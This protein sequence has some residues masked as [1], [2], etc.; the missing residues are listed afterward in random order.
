MLFKPLCIVTVNSSV[1]NLE[2]FL[3]LEKFIQHLHHVYRLVNSYVF[4][5]E[6]Y[7]IV[8]LLC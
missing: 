7:K 4:K 8:K 6:I 5:K 1:F 2:R 3:M